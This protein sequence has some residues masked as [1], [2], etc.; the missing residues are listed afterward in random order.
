[1]TNA[2]I[3]S[4]IISIVDDDESVLTAVHSLVSSYGFEAYMFKSAEEFLKSPY[5]SDTS[6][7]LSDV[8]MPNMSGLTLQRKLLE[9]GLKIPTIFMT[10]FTNEGIK[11]RAIAGGALCFLIKPLETGTLIKCI[12]TALKKNTDLGGESPNVKS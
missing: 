6:C 3:K 8:H 10:A 11:E 1:M 7:L 12:N 5:L 4:R 2:P 9:Q